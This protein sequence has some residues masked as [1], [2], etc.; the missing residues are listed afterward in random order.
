MD[1]FL[2]HH[3]V[4]G[5]SS[6]DLECELERRGAKI[7]HSPLSGEGY[8]TP[9]EESYARYQWEHYFYP[10]ADDLWGEGF[11][12]Y[13]EEHWYAIRGEA[14]L[15]EPVRGL[16]KDLLTAIFRDRI[17]EVVGDS[18]D[19]VFS[20]DRGRWLPGANPYSGLI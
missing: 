16:R 8:A 6:A 18:I 13:A 3:P 20:D 12:A 10:D 2:K 5:L 1:S 9:S 19:E 15:R 4:A 7:V 14:A 11:R 17:P